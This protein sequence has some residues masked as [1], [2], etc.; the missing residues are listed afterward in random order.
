ME[1]KQQ[2]KKKKKGP[3]P[4]PPPIYIPNY[5]PTLSLTDEVINYV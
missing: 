3:P 5:K 1:K 4:P 2:R